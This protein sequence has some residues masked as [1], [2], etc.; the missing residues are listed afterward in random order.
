MLKRS[1]SKYW[2]NSAIYKRSK[3]GDS[4]LIQVSKEPAVKYETIDI[5]EQQKIKIKATEEKEEELKNPHIIEISDTGDLYEVLT[6]FYVV[7][8]NSKE[9]CF[10]IINSFFFCCRNTISRSRVDLYI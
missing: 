7:R 4:D 3:L 5:A 1:L 10:F 9:T 8:K 2:N 6:F